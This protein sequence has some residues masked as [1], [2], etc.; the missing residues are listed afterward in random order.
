MF[1][2]FTSSFSECL[3]VYDGFDC[4]SSWLRA[5]WEKLFNSLPIAYTHSPPSGVC[6]QFADNRWHLDNQLRQLSFGCQ[7]TCPFWLSMN[8]CICASCVTYFLLTKRRV[9]V[10]NSYRYFFRG[11]PHF[12]F[13]EKVGIFS[14]S[15]TLHGATITNCT[16]NPKW[17]ALFTF[18]QKCEEDV[19]TNVNYTSSCFVEL[20]PYNLHFR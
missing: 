19:V 4:A 3:N 1:L 16:D 7:T 5:Y 18:W 20:D 15:Q 10:W 11:V 6:L 14:N 8:A 9:C 13:S 17:R 2:L 12:G